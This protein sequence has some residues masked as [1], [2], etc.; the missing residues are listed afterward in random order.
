ME[1]AST[2]VNW[3][4]PIAMGAVFIVLIIGLYALFRGGEFGRSWSNKMMRLRVMAQFGAIMV[5]LLALFLKE[6]LG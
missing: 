1:N 6:R 3:L 4:V 2:L 5:L